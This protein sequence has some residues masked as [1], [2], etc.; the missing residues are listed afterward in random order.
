MYTLSGSIN[1]TKINNVYKQHV[2]VLYKHAVT[3]PESIPI[4]PETPSTG[5]I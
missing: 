5:N 1:C 4:I 3:S 2:D